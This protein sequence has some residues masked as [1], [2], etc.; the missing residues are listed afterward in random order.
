MKKLLVTLLTAIALIGCL[1]TANIKPL[2]PGA[3]SCGSNWDCPAGYYC[4][5]PGVDTYAQCLPR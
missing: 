2:P 4:G 3:K 5:F 1:S